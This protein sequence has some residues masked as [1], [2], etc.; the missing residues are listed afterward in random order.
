M[1]NEIIHW[2]FKLSR[3][4]WWGGQFERLVGLV[5]RALYKSIENSCLTWS[6]LQDVLLDIEVTL[7]NRPLGYQE[8]NIEL[9]TLMPN[10]LQFVGTAVLPEL[11]PHHEENRNLRKR[12]RYL[13]TCKVHMWKR[14][15]TVY[16]RG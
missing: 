1:A 11:E 7:N 14:W 9:L 15:S 6:E 8:N 10:S 5:K 16:L 13:K 3:A 4:P 12:E 2:Q